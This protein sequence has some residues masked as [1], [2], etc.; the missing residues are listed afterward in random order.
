LEW[1]YAGWHINDVWSVRIGRQKFQVTRSFDVKAENQQAIER[2]ASSYYWA[3]STITNGIKFVG[4]FDNARTNVM[5]GNGSSSEG[6]NDSWIDNGHGWGITGRVEFLLTG[7]WKQFV[8]IGTTPGGAEGLL[9]GLGAGYLRNDDQ[10][11]DN[12]LVSSDLSYQSDDGWNLYGT[13][14]AGDNNSGLGSE[15]NSMVNDDLGIT[16]FN[17]FQDNDG[18]SVGF[19]IG[20]GGY[21]SEKTELYS[22]WQWLSPGIGAGDTPLS[23][24]GDPS[25]KLNMLTLGVNH[26]LDNPHVKLSLD[27]TWSFTDPSTAFAYG[28]GAWGY[29]GWWASENGLT[30]GSLWL[31]RAQMQLSF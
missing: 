8:R 6:G 2:S 26:Y 22:R 10:S 11:R 14:T 30:T 3:T 13:L 24:A 18:I 25:A 28:N 12:W 31:L 1:A 5:I 7:D 4:D 23:L 20:A 17:G 21:I 27:W 15:L 9:L 16:T 29:T 19:E